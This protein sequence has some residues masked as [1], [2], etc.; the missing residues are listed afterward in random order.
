[1]DILLL[2][3]LNQM[4]SIWIVPSMELKLYSKII[5]FAFEWKRTDYIEIVFF[6]LTTRVKLETFRAFYPRLFWKESVQSFFDIKIELQPLLPDSFFFK[7]FLERFVVTFHFSVSG[8][9]GFGG[10]HTPSFESIL[11]LQPIS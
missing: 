4:N 2:K 8:W 7:F 3:Q 6:G 9:S 11:F 5:D 1:M 10:F